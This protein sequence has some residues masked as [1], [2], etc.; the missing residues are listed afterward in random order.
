MTQENNGEKTAKSSRN[1]E[2]ISPAP[3]ARSYK[4]RLFE[5]IFHK[6]DELL[7]LYNA[8]NGTDYQDPELLEINTLEN[9][10][11]MSMKNDISFIIDFQLY[12]YEHQSTYSPNLPL[13]YLLYVSDLYSGMVQGKNLYGT[14]KVGLPTPHFLIFYNGVKERP[15]REILKLSDLFQIEEE[16]YSLELTA[17]MLNINPGHNRELLDSCRRL[18]DYSEYTNRVRRYAGSGSLEQAVERAITECI[19]EGILAD[20]LEKYRAEVKSV[21]IY[22]YN[23]E[24]TG[25]RKRGR[26]KRRTGRGKR[27]RTKR[28][29]RRGD[30]D[31][32][33]S[34]K[35]ADEPSASGAEKGRAHGR[36][37]SCRRPGLSGEALSGVWTV[38]KG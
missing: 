35:K 37:R 31:G 25:R 8:V 17:V 38:G 1:V 29:Q 27:G 15:D 16:E 23:E 9:A 24:R 20:F 12:L 30:P 14:K 21:S 18:K 33:Q 4:A 6:K 32:R 3:A 7:K 10:V 26:T 36:N 19:Q 2:I 5:M 13:R 22:E 34:G 11:Y 28:R